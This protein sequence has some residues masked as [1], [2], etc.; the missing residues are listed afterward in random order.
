M[1][2]SVGTF[3][4]KVKIYADGYTD[5]GAIRINGQDYTIYIQIEKEPERV[6]EPVPE[7]IPEIPPEM[8]TE[9]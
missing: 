5:V 1:N 9:S 2:E 8:E 4:P 6:P 7:I 3:M